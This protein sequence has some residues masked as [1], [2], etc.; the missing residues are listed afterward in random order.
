MAKTAMIK[1]GDIVKQSLSQKENYLLYKNT[2]DRHVASNHTIYGAPY[3]L[4]APVFYT[5]EQDAMFAAMG[6]DKDI[7]KDHMKLMAKTDSRWKIRGVDHAINLAVC[8]ALQLFADLKDERQTIN[9]LSYFICFQYTLLHNKYWGQS[10][11]KNGPPESVMMYAVNNMSDKFRLRATGNLWG[12]LYETTRGCYDYHKVKIKKGEDEDFVRFIADARTR[13]NNILKAI[14][15]EFYEAYTQKNYMQTEADVMDEEK[16]HEVDNNTQVVERITNKVLTN[17]IVNGPDARI[18][19]LAAK[20]ATVSVNQLR[21]YCSVLIREN[22]RED[23]RVIIE[24]LLYMY[25]NSE[26]EMHT[27][28]GIYSNDFM[29]YCLK[30]YKKAHTLD[31]NVIRIKAILDAWLIELGIHSPTAKSMNTTTSNFRR[32]LYFFMVASIMNSR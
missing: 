16:Y 24:C 8:L 32:A 12:L 10:F 1:F 18:V 31:E 28:Q 19:E 27:V 4:K 2:I 6:L 15:H 17:L 23:I 20:S 5:K 25:L 21:N 14:S 3:P 7:V 29:V 30:V 11:G 22:H 26:S 9:A 13:L